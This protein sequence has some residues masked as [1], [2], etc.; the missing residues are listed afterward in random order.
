[1]TATDLTIQYLPTG[2]RR[3]LDTF[4]AERAAGM[5]AYMLTRHRLASVARMYA[6]SDADLRAMGLARRDIPAFVFE[7]MLPDEPVHA[8][9]HRA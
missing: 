2:W 3:D 7:D 6:L 8:R 1:M 4:M 9:G 5:N